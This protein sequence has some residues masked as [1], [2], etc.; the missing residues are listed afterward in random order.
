M[1][2]VHYFKK[3]NNYY[4][5]D[6]EYLTIYKLPETMTQELDEMEEQK[7]NEYFNTVKYKH[8]KT[9]ENKTYMNE[10]R[11]RRLIINLSTYCNLACKYC[12]AN[13]GN[14]QKSCVTMEIKTLENAIKAVMEIYPDGIEYIQFFGGE[15]LLNKQVLIQGIEFIDKYIENLNKKLPQYTIVTNGTLIDNEILDLFEKKFTSVTV[16]LDGSK[17]IN[18]ISRVFK[19]KEDSVYD[20]VTSAINL[21]NKSRRTYLLS[22]EMT[23]TPYHIKDFM[24]NG[25]KIM[26]FVKEM[27]VDTIQMSPV[28]H[29]FDDNYNLEKLFFEDV[30][31]FF[32]QWVVETFN[33]KSD[34]KGKYHLV[35]NILNTISKKCF[36]GNNCGAALSDISIDADGDIYPCFM[37]IGYQ[38]YL[39]GNVNSFSTKN[40]LEKNKIIRERLK[41]AN[42]NQEC[43]QCWA[44]KF[45]SNSYG[46]CI[47]SR[48]LLTGKIDKP[49][50]LACDIGKAIIEQTIV[51]S[52]NNFGT[53]Y[54]N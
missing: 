5:V 27:E 4:V 33:K 47:G 51:L 23:I 6:G 37:F 15:P 35:G 32:E 53:K 38:D 43:N 8:Y 7:L 21:M 48:L 3:N 25:K 20:K 41:C 39:L 42:D 12:Y 29:S 19:N 40:L 49:V 13:G 30:K 36:A 26:D 22:L 9:L 44:K 2:L 1:S 45:C 17:E 52:V 34:L 11:C 14:Y 10:K 31:T 46:H 16:S 24:E 18:D 50:S 28:F 54:G